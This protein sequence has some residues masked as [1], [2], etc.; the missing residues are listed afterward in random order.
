LTTADATAVDVGPIRGQTVVDDRPLATKSLKLSVQPGYFTVPADR[1]IKLGPSPD[2]ERRRLASENADAEPPL[3]VA[4]DKERL[5]CAF[6]R[7]DLLQFRGRQR[8]LRKWV[9]IRRAQTPENI[10]SVECLGR[11]APD[12]RCIRVVVAL[13][14]LAREVAKE[15]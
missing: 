6:R 12:R 3:P 7:H 8:M 11:N 2:R 13:D 1:D 15:A 14:Q 9:P 4:E 10:P 5:L